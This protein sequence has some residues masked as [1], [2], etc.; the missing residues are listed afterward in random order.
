M[1][2]ASQMWTITAQGPKRAVQNAA[3]ALAW[4]DPSPANAVSQFE[5]T[6]FQWRMEALAE[7]EA[8]AKDAVKIAAGVAPDIDWRIAPLVQEDWIAKSLEGLPAVPVGRFIVAGQH[9]APKAGPYRRTIRIEAGEAFGTG[10]HGTTKGC[11]AALEYLARRKRIGRVLDL[12]GGT[13]VLAIAASRAGASFAAATDIDARAT[14]VAARN[15]K[16]NRAPVRT[17]TAAGFSATR[18]RHLG[19]FDLIFANI[20]MKP[21]IRLSPEV[22]RA[23]RPGGHL[24]LSGILEAQEP[25]V[26][27]A[28]QNRGLVFVR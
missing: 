9:A 21:L 24:I 7:T 15:A 28:Y 16:D 5:I 8:R 20:L 27:D 25:L 11:L 4:A 18:V 3:N 1:T 10:H 12:G 6:R 19:R 22:V 23:L 17:L 26:R 13:G 14:E 2:Q